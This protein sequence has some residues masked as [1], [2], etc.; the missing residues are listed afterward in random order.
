LS[1]LVQAP[2]MLKTCTGTNAL[3]L[4]TPQIRLGTVW[5]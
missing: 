3:L 1:H 2:V 5:R 4:M